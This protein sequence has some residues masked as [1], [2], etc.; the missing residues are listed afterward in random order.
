MEWQV[1][2][3]KQSEV[4]KFYTEVVGPTIS[5][6]PDVLR[7]RVFEVDNATVLQGDQY[8]T[9]EKEKLLTYF[10]LIE[11]DSEQWPW[12]VV[13]ELAQNEKWI[14]YFES[15]KVVVSTM[16]DNCM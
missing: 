3:E 4:M 6:S 15:Q 1:S 14:E 7:F 12:D 2:T 11:L 16:S 8:I 5:S 10:T 13:F 9:Q